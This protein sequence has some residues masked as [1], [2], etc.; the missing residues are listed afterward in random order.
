MSKIWDLAKFSK[1]IQYFY[2]C[3]KLFSG[4]YFGGMLGVKNNGLPLFC[5]FQEITDLLNKQPTGHYFLAPLKG[6][7][8]WLVQQ[9]KREFE[10]TKSTWLWETLWFFCYPIRLLV[11][12]QSTFSDPAKPCSKKHD[13]DIAKFSLITAGR[14]AI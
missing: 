9:I 11:K 5:Q 8:L 7:R 3:W 4:L 6:W 1:K 10:L 2:K 12:P 14:Y 13:L